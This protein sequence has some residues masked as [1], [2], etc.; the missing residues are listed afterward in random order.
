MTQWH[1]R[2]HSSGVMIYWH[3]NIQ[4]ICIYSQLKTCTSSEVAAMLQ[5]LIDHQTD[6]EVQS[7]STDSHGKSDLGFALT[8]LLG[9]D[10]LPRYKFL[11]SEKLYS[12]T[13]NFKTKHLSSIM[14]LE[15]KWTLIATQY[16][17]MVRHT[18]ALKIGTAQADVFVRKFSRSNYGHA[19]FKAFIELGRAIKTIFLCR[20]L[21]SLELR[22]QIHSGLNLVENW[23]AANE[24]IYY[25][26]SGDFSTN[27]PDEQEISMLCLHLL[28]VSLTYVKTLFVQDIF[29][30]KRLMRLFQTENFRELTPLFHNHVNSYG[31]F[32]LDLNKRLN[33][34][35]IEKVA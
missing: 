8:Y 20:Y 17:D 18:A 7:H 32:I 1:P 35:N 33:I 28:Q 10:L 4:S 11:G 21:D 12:P 26:K 25:G 27:S 24:F 13:E 9:F 5:G 14:T 6:L 19:T 16:D 34:Q 2:Y 15:I 29:S 31:S 30:E 22:K 3:V 23:N